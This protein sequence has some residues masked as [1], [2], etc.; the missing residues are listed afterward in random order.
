M[1]TKLF[2]M[3]DSQESPKRKYLIFFFLVSIFYI[4]F[5]TKSCALDLFF[6]RNTCKRCQGV[7]TFS[8]T[9]TLEVRL[10]VYLVE[11]KDKYVRYL[12]V[13]S[14]IVLPSQRQVLGAA[15]WIVRITPH[16][17]KMK[18][19]NVGETCILFGWEFKSASFLLSP[20]GLIKISVLEGKI[21]NKLNLHHRVFADIVYCSASCVGRQ[22]VI[23]HSA[24]LSHS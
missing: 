16:S 12:Q 2:Y 20:K 15:T 23:Y 17:I 3:T 18:D 4:H 11:L 10:P 5:L 8:S 6:H 7:S 14:L 21:K 9:I 22:W 24:A 19:R 1:E 13:L